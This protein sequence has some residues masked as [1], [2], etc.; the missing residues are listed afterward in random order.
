M[1]LVFISDLH[2]KL[3][4]I[5][6]PPADVLCI[7]GDLTI[8][9]TAE[10]LIR[11]NADLGRIRHKYKYVVCIAG[12]HDR[13][14]AEDYYH[15]KSLLT[16]ASHYLQDELVELDGV[17]FYGSPWTITFKHWYFMLNRGPQIRQKW[18]MVPDGVDVLLTHSPPY[19]IFDKAK[20]GTNVG[21]RDLF[22]KVMKI[23][24]RIH[25]FGHVHEDAP[26]EKNING[27]LFIN[28][29]TCDLSFRPVNPPIEVEI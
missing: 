28:A 2:N 15:A 19:G 6:P 27:T 8:N 9:G 10:E 13:L 24:P 26:G 17:K 12:N 16:N 23:K 25:A 1:R 4:Q 29:V 18:D 5:D 14:L 11:F 22:D 21:C 20:D 7:C 3:G